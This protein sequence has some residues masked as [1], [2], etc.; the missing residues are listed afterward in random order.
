M[1]AI[2]RTVIVVALGLGLC[3]GVREAPA[4]AARRS[5]DL[6]RRA[7]AAAVRYDRAVATLSR[8]GDD[9]AALEHKMAAVESK[10]APLRATVTRRAVAVYTSDRGLDAFAG[11]ADGGDIVESAR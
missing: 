7:D 9:I 4:G 2:L 6:Q 5:G 1:R 11:F 10:M 3:L 8:L